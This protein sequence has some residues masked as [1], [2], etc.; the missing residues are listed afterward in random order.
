MARTSDVVIYTGS[1]LNPE[2]LKYCKKDAELHDSAKMGLPEMLKIMVE[3]IKADK[4]VVRLH[5]G[6]PSF[7]GAIQEV[8]TSLD[9]EGIEYFRIPGISCLLGGAA[10]LNREL[11]LPNISQ[12]VI[13]TRPEG[14]TPVPAE[15]SI[16]KLARTKQHGY[17]SVHLTSVESSTTSERRLPKDTPCQV[18]YKATWPEQKI[19]KGT[20]ADIVEKV[21]AAG[22]TETALIFVGRVL[23]PKDYDLSK[24][25]DP[26]FT[27]G[28]RK[29]EE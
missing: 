17:F 15:E 26:K 9:R 29:G 18:V 23:D 27:T 13:I 7:Y 24:L 20:L 12:T 14:R 3:G 11:T 19:V 28:F 8:M 4:L 25:Y 1:L 6:D 16:Q 5:D 22:I 10:A 2:Y 21:K